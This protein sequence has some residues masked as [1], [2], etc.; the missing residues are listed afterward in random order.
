M[1]FI[2]T[3]A[4]N[5]AG[6]APTLR[7]LLENV[8]V[9]ARDRAGETA[10]DEKAQPVD[11]DTAAP[12]VEERASRPARRSLRDRLTPSEDVQQRLRAWWHGEVRAGSPPPPTVKEVVETY[13]ADEPEWSPERVRVSET[14]WGKAFIEPGGVQA[15]RKLFLPIM[16]KSKHSVLDLAAGLGGTAQ[17]L[18]SSQNLWMDAFEPNG[19]LVNRARRNIR[20]AGR[21][22]QVPITE[23]SF[24]DM[25]IGQRKYDLV[26]AR[27]RLFT[28]ENKLD[29]LERAT[30]GLKAG[31]QILITDYLLG[32][33]ADTAALDAWR[34]AEPVLPSAWTLGLYARALESFGLDVWARHNLTDVYLGDVYAT[35]NRVLGSVVES[36]FDRNLGKVLLR[37]GEIWSARTRALEAG[38]LVYCRII[39]SKH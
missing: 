1:R 24:D 25:Q 22:Q 2:L 26:Y 10:A 32:G 23:V 39:A 4:G 11:A 17:T 31:G 34:R 8:G 18:A 27:D 37:E 30:A 35:W 38:D 12:P 14:L 16:P 7:R 36:G 3:K 33:E 5:K 20:R 9:L 13:A 15:T 19:V 29:L 6:D 28:Y 21:S